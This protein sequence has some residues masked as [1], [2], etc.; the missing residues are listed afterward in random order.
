MTK[1]AFKWDGSKDPLVMANKNAKAC[2]LPMG[3][4]AENVASQFKVTRW[5]VL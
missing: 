1:D 4:T 2:L 5:L 3:L